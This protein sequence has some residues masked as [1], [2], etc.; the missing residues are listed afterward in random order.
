MRRGNRTHQRECSSIDYLKRGETESYGK[1]EVSRGRK[2][3][4]MGSASW[5]GARGGA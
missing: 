1:V 2:G 5:I 3:G 4:K